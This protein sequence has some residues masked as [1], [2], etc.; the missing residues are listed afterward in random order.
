MVVSYRVT[1][2]SNQVPILLCYLR[3]FSVASGSFLSLE[4][5]WALA[6]AQPHT[7]AAP[8][9]VDEFDAGQVKDAPK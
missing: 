6:F 9:L 7:W 3:F 2:S 1:F 8:V 5:F 4:L